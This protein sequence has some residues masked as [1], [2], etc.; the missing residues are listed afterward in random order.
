MV[1]NDADAH[2]C[3]VLAS[4][5]KSL[6]FA[7]ASLAITC[8]RGQKFPRCHRTT[9]VDPLSAA[10]AEQDQ[11]IGGEIG[12]YDRIVCDVPCS[13]DGTLR[14]TPELWKAWRPSLALQLH[15]LQ[16]Q[17]A[18]RGAALLK[19]GAIMTYS[20]C[21][22]SPIENESVV[23][24]LLQRCGGAL[25]AVDSTDCLAHLA[26]RPGLTHWSVLDDDLR[27]WPSFASTRASLDLSAK[28]RQAFR[29]SMWPPAQVEE[30]RSGTESLQ[31]QLKR[32][33]RF[34]PHISDTGGF[35]I[36]V[37]RKIAPFPRPSQRQSK[38]ARQ[39]LKDRTVESGAVP[40]IPASAQPLR[41]HHRLHSLAT[42]LRI[43]S[44]ET[45]VRDQLRLLFGSDA[46]D[47]LLP[48]LL[49]HSARCSK[50]WYAPAAIR[51]H[52]RFRVAGT[53]QDEGQDAPAVVEAPVS[54][55]QVGVC[56]CQRKRTRSKK[57]RNRKARFQLTPEGI[58]LARLSNA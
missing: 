51:E 35:F 43:D 21:S 5:M 39:G 36:V 28:Q 3:H 8:H 6:G 1:A 54:L 27:R 55:V 26:R 44:E 56:V 52:F 10:A 23:A 12:E 15:S 42:C 32:C 47:H 37:L 57:S 41:Q 34:Y 22:L 45:C 17:I 11:E 4:K 40:P 38:G 7:S 25:E 48:H 31:C 49:S 46:F 29:P 58:E 24:A 2:R 33:L 18:L 14:K 19:V 53:G 20:T 30:A 16:L 9:D 13:G 50:I